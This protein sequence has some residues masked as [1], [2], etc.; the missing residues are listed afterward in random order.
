MR[1]DI[2]AVTIGDPEYPDRL[3]A[4]QRRRGGANGPLGPDCP[5]L[6]CR[7]S[8]AALNAARSAAVIGTREPTAYGRQQA[9]AFGRDLAAAGYVIVSGL[10]RGCDTAAHRGCVEAGGASVAVLAH[11]LDTIY[12]PENAGLADELIRHGGC[13]VSEY[14]PGTPPERRAFALRDRI[15]S[16]LAHLV[17]V[18]ETP[19]DDGTM[20]T[21]DFARRQSRPIG[22]LVHSPERADVPQA[23]GN[24]LLLSGGA[25]PF[26]TPQDALSALRDLCGRPSGPE[27]C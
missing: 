22:C 19:G 27:A 24:A 21:V 2:T 13:L 3:A 4:L 8:V 7:G 26:R 6:Y 16:A 14:P 9:R 15:Q 10:A 1:D 23:A 18:I 25:L 12:P 5:I 11:G 17:I 20:I